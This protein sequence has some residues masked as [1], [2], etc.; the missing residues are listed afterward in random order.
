LPE[1]GLRRGYF[2]QKKSGSTPRLF[3][4]ASPGT[5]IG[6]PA[7]TAS[8][9]SQITVKK[10]FILLAKNIPAGG[11]GRYAHEKRAAGWQPLQFFCTED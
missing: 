8:K 10:P 2:S 4:G 6:V 9:G 1:Y 3:R 11:F 7:C 5:A